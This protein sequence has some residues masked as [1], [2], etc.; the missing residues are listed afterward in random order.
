MEI[1]FKFSATNL[2]NFLLT[3]EKL[4]IPANAKKFFILNNFYL[5]VK[6]LNKLLFTK[7]NNSKDILFQIYE[8]NLVIYEFEHTATKQ[9]S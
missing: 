8:F 1:F 5:L 2:A 6:L 9:W 3:E 4:L 7:V